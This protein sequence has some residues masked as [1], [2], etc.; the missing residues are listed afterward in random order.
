MH[1]IKV[2]AAV[3]NQPPLDWE[4]NARNIVSA[5]G[6]AR[7]KG[8]GVLCLPE[9]CLT[10][11]GCEDAFHGSFV[12]CTAWEMLQDLARETKGMV[13]ALGLPVYFRNALFNTAAVLVDGHIAG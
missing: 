6:D 11:Y 7:S 4:G 1:L 8:V 9:L 13:V 2:A 12:H 3:L 10:G 5:I